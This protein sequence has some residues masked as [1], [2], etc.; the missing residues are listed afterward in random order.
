[1]YF[2][3]NTEKASVKYQKLEMGEICRKKAKKLKEN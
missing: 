1:M 2:S 3:K